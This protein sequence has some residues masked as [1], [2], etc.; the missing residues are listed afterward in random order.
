MP[1]RNEARFIGATLRQLLD[2]EYPADRFEIIVADGMSDDGTREIIMSLAQQHPNIRLLDNPKRLSSAGR[3][4]GFNNGRGEYFL[5]IDGHC[6]IPHTRLFLNLVDCFSSSRAACL[7]RPQPLDP[8]G[9]TPFQ[10]SVALVRG[11]RIGHGGDSLIYGEYEGF[12]SPASNGAAYTRQALETVGSV[13]E[14]FDA[15][16]DVEFNY[17]VEQAGFTCYTSPRLTVRYYPRSS[18]AGLFRQMARYGKGRRRFTRK[19]PRA[20]TVDQLIPAAFVVGLFALLAALGLYL[21]S[22]MTTPLL[23]VAIPYCLYLLLVAGESIRVAVR[24]GIRYAIPVPMIIFVIHFAL[25]YGFLK[26]T[27]GFIRLPGGPVKAEVTGRCP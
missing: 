9:L 4:V 21:F 2:Q 3:N 26:E 13:D 5:V 25:G 12:A 24:D 14:D 7:G 10:T 16:E 17:R 20:R 18:L 8:P 15:A 19:H 23:L 27:A 6:F 11:S 22:G 1:V